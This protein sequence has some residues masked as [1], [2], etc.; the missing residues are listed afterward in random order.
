MCLSSVQLER[1]SPQ[2]KPHT[3]TMAST[4]YSAAAFLVKDKH[5][6]KQEGKQVN[7]GRGLQ[8]TDLI[9]FWE[10]GVDATAA[11]AVTSAADMPTCMR[12]EPL[13]FDSCQ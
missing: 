6:A 9:A 3:D 2:S 12:S 5:K 7:S 8:F 1:A 4:P 10:I 13:Y 11:H